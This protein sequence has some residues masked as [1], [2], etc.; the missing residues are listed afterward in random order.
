MCGDKS[1][2]RVKV[3]AVRVSMGQDREGRHVGNA[4]G[5]AC[6]EETMSGRRVK[7]DMDM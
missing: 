5:A 3:M 1:E 2:G 4:D 7:D 6:K